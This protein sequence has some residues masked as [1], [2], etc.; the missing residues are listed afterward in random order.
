MGPRDG[1][2]QQEMYSWFWGMFNMSHWAIEMHFCLMRNVF[3]VL[4]FFAFNA[5]FFCY[6]VD[7]GLASRELVWAAWIIQW[8]WFLH[9]PWG[10]CVKRTGMPANWMSLCAQCMSD[11][12]YIKRQNKTK[13]K[14]AE[15]FASWEIVDFH[16]IRV[17]NMT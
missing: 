11:L 15:F 4:I 6:T 5:T 14:N 17:M 3:S 12:S 10:I 8:K 13:K 16:H 2:C 7:Q 9:C 1:G